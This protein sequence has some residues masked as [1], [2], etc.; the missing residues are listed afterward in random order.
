[1]NSKI[2]SLY[3]KVLEKKIDG[4][5]ECSGLDFGFLVLGNSNFLTS[6]HCRLFFVGEQAFFY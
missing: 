2:T 1:V 5:I 6:H 4:L 3:R